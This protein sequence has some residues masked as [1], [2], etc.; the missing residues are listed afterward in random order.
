MGMVAEVHL[1]FAAQYQQLVAQA[2][3]RPKV[4]CSCGCCAAKVSQAGG[5]SSLQQ[6]SLASE[7]LVLQ[8]NAL[9]AAPCL[10][11]L[12]AQRPHVNNNQI[13]H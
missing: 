10:K 7:A 9:Q 1:G 12:Q 5:G 11:A 6:Q 4:E 8:T 13:G 3:A 2:G